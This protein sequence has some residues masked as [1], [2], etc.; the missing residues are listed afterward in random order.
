MDGILRVLDYFVDFLGLKINYIKI[1]MVWI[2]SK[3]FLREVF[4]YIRWKL[5][6]NN[7][8]FDLLGIKFFVILDEMFS[9]N[10][11]FKLLDIK[12]ILN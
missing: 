10:Y 1:K 4:Y 5:N 2:G 9:F 8:I 11:E 12:R 6:W 3:K 7:L